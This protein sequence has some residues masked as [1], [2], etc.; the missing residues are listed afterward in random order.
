MFFL[1]HR[2][3]RPTGD[4]LARALGLPHGTT[5][6]DDRQD[7]LIRWG[8]Q[9]SVRYRPEVTINPAVAI[10]RATQK[11]ESLVRMKE[12]G[13]VVPPFAY[14]P[15]ELQAPYLGRLFDHTRGQDI[16][17]CMQLSDTMR[18]RRDFYTQYIPVAREYRARVVGNECVRVSEKVHTGDTYVPWI[19][20][21][22][23]GH[24]FVSPRTRLNAFQKALAVAAV[25]AHGLD[26]GAV[27]L[28]VGD[29]GH[30]YVLEV[31]TAPA[32]APMSASAMLGGLTRLIAERAGVELEL[33]I[34]VLGELSASD[35][36]DTEDDTDPLEVF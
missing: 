3:T 18:E 32:L 24:T 1:Y 34:E 35:D 21:Y 30:T 22:E 25:K 19:R 2:T 20:N 9:A 12:R 6:P 28:V 11:Y 15:R 29:D 27:D 23:T 10:G 36:G 13:V 26:F 31:N 4:V 5:P 7:I 8:S 33:D 14:D 17:L 16:I